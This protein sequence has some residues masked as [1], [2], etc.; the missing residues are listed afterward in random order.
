[1]KIPPCT[2]LILFREGQLF[3][4]IWN[5]TMTRSTIEAGGYEPLDVGARVSPCLGR[6]RGLFGR[7]RSMH[8]TPLLILLAASACFW[9][10]GTAI[11]LRS[12]LSPLRPQAHWG[13]ASGDP[14]LASD[15][16]FPPSIRGGIGHIIRLGEHPSAVSRLEVLLSHFHHPRTFL[17][18]ETIS[19]LFPGRLAGWLAASAPAS[20]RGWMACCLLTPRHGS[21][22]RRRLLQ[23]Q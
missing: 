3:F 20:A 8:V 4:K 10:E 6:G 15:F 5:R 13:G 2:P 23:I 16:R 1:M 12:S 21:R 19:F 7:S 11:S 17:I 22:G 14:P 18:L 9:C